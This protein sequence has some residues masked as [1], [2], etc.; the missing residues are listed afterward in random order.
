MA[1]PLD[2]A[3]RTATA[4]P[5]SGEGPIAE[6]P[7]AALPAR[8][9]DLGFLASGASSD[10]R[11]VHDTLLDCDLAMKVLRFEHAARPAMRTRF[12]NEATITAQ[13]RHPGIIAVH[14]RGEL[15]DGR[16][17]Y[18]MTLVRGRTLRAVIDEVHGAAGPAGFAEAASGW[19]FPRLVD[20]FARVCEAVAFAH[21]NGV[22]HRD[23]KP[24]N[25]MVSA[26]GE[27]LVMDWGLARRLG[28][29][30]DPGG[31]DGDAPGDLTRHGDIL[32][33]PA[34]MPPEQALGQ[35]DRHG[36]ASDVYALG[37]I[38]HH[39]LAGRPPYHGRGDA[40]WRKVL[41]GPPA[42]VTE[43]ARGGPP[44]PEALAAICERAM[45][46]AIEDRYPA[47]GPLAAALR[48]WLD[49]ARR[50]DQALAILDGA[51]AVAPRVEALRAGA[52]AE[53]RAARAVFASLRPSDPIEAKRPG[54]AREDE[55][56]RLQREAALAEVEWITTVSG[57]LRVD[58]NLPEAHALLADHYRAA[59]EQAERARR[60]EDAARFEYLLRQHDRGR[61]AV[62]LRGE[63]ALTL[64]TDPPG[65]EV[66]IH[67]YA[68]RDRR[69]VPGPPAPL[70]PTPI[71][72][73]PLPCGSYLLVL[74]A[75]G[76]AE[77]RYP[78]LVERGEHWDGRAPGDAEPTPIR[79]PLAGEM[80][81]DEVYVPAGYAWIGGDADAADSLPRR[82]IRI[83]GLFLG[84]HPVTH[85]AYLA[86]L[87]DRVAEG[88]A[89]EA[90]DA[91]PKNTAGAAYGRDRAGLFT[92]AGGS[93]EPLPL[94]DRPVSFVTWHG[95]AAYARW[96]AE[97]TGRPFRLPDELEREKA[98]RGADGRA[99]PFGDHPDPRFACAVESHVA[100][101]APAAVDDYAL[102]ES[103]YGARGLG[104]NSRDW[105]LGVWRQDGP[106]IE[107]GRLQLAPASPDNPDFRAVRG[108]A[109]A[110]PQSFGRA[111][112][113]FANPP[114][115]GRIMIGFRTARSA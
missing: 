77:V 45:R 41:A 22:V 13:L 4:S 15:G 37:A 103:P 83:D 99:F 40:S 86:F 94:P 33:T 3:D 57:A 109:W 8:Y 88:R 44:I 34:Y 111:A 10:V 73:V 24:D 110:S 81:A 14:D 87:N 52:E 50:R 39:L 100:P 28:G 11:R 27:A 17:W 42:P 36:P 107:G 67:R 49:G 56:A 64:I 106:P 6:G 79:L 43:A 60:R 71:V 63:G 55:A 29:R 48:A 97:A 46:R 90:L 92:L 91:C 85:A 93:L 20:A 51:A 58:P 18:T 65:A 9:R 115:P 47:A 1:E 69:L 96:L 62:F 80:S 7:R 114:G 112:C 2:R 66:T 70:G 38:L 72:E 21:D 75:P 76:R 32:G 35:R 101:P 78:V 113:R 61:H 26:L 68:A 74:R 23:L 53:L 105:C 12:R 25:V 59:F 98:A 5:L 95:A 82:R 84:R 16:P 104:G 30:D 31:A 19:T 89:D 54:W 102:D 108:G